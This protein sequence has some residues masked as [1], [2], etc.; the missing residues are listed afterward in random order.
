M[1]K[2]WRISLVRQYYSPKG[3]HAVEERIGRKL[4]EKVRKV[5]TG[6]TPIPIAELRVWVIWRAKPTLIEEKMIIDKM[7]DMLDAM[8][9]YAF[10]SI[11]EAKNV[12]AIFISREKPTKEEIEI[13]KKG[14]KAVTIEIDG[15]EIEEMDF[16]EFKEVIRKMP[17]KIK[18]GE[19]YMYACFYDENGEVHYEYG[20][21]QIQDLIAKGVAL[22]L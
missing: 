17:T 2:V 15:Y 13:R 1:V 9:N 10:P 14:I 21:E 20:N 16:D 22:G 7:N 8:E 19:Y 12:G 4:R 18:F 6:E 3:V 11:R 5:T